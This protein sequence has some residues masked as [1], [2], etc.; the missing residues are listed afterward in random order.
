MDSFH[1]GDVVPR[2][3]LPVKK[4][5]TVVVEIND[6]TVNCDVV[7]VNAVPAALETIIEFGEKTDEPV[8]PF[9]VDRV[10]AERVPFEAETAP[11][12]V[13]MTAVPPTTARW[14]TNPQSGATCVEIGCKNS[15]WVTGRISVTACLSVQPNE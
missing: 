2:P 7:A 5:S 6:P 14:P 3:R 4:E 13:P 15:E 10:P 8:P 12:S 9:A 11:E 1:F